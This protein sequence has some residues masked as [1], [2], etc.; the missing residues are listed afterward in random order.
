MSVIQPEERV[1]QPFI[2]AKERR[3]RHRWKE[4]YVYF[5]EKGQ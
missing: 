1:N 4:R 3:E 2:C 5:K